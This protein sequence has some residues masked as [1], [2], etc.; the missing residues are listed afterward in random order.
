MNFDDLELANQRVCPPHRHGRQLEM[1][2]FSHH[3]LCLSFNTHALHALYGTDRFKLAELTA[4]IMEPR[5]WRLTPWTTAHSCRQCRAPKSL[6][7]DLGGKP[8]YPERAHEE[9]L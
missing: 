3:I 6:S 2:P 4:L 7:L 9:R 5:C 1:T 8:E